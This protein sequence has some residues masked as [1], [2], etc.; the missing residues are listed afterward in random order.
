MLMAVVA[1]FTV[2]SVN[3]SASSAFPSNDKDGIKLSGSEI[4]TFQLNP[5][6]E[7]PEFNLNGD[8]VVALA[9][10]PSCGSGG[11]WLWEFDHS[12]KVG[13][14]WHMYESRKC[15]ETIFFISPW[16][17]LIPMT[18]TTTETREI[19]IVMAD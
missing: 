4:N 9:T 5:S 10:L 16:G 19:E 18:Y 7:I 17:G 13:G 14:V 12:E 11:T 8:D 2:S 15:T 3:V 6:P 1:I